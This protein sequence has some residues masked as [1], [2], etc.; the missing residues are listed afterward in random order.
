MDILSYLTQ[1]IVLSSVGIII[2]GIIEETN[3]LSIIKKITKPLCLISNLP[4]E[5]VVALLGNFINP[6]VG[7]SMLAKFYKDNKINSKE[8]IITTIISPLPII[9][10][11]SIFRV[12]LPLAIVLLGYKLGTI[13]VLFNMFSGFL[14][15]SIGIIYS[16]IFFERKPININTNNNEKII[17]NREVITKGVMKSVE[18]L[19]KVIF[20]ILNLPGE[21]VMVL[22][23]N[24]AHFSAGYATVD[25][26]IKN[27]VLNEKQALLT[28]LIGNIIGV[29]MIYLKHSI[30]TYV[31]LFGKFGLK[32]AMINYT[33]SII[34][35]I[36]LITLVMLIL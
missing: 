1:I 32:L 2:A 29:T 31:A 26:L 34:I 24:F 11:E 13:Y 23:A 6:T 10:G 5:C 20:G 18:L 3:L 21:A 25:I 12:Q 28:L 7:K 14:M 19:K 36:I 4:E 8:T 9:L 30:G 27:G 33:I 17:F 16:N 35:K 15:A 22:V